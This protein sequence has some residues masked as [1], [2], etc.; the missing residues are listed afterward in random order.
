[1]WKNWASKQKQN[2]DNSFM[3][4]LSI[5]LM[6]IRWHL[7]MALHNQIL[8]LFKVYF[9]SAL[10]LKIETETTWFIA[11]NSVGFFGWS[12]TSVAAHSF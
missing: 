12:G 10:H 9:S 1:M 8:V 11:A 7:R 5:L 3:K 6:E 4:G 2:T